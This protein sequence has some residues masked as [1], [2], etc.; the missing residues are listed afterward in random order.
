[1]FTKQHV[2][3]LVSLGL[4]AL[5]VVLLA[6]NLWAFALVPFFLMAIAILLL[7]KHDAR[8]IVLL[9]SPLIVYPL[10]YVLLGKIYHVFLPYI[11]SQGMHLFIANLPIIILGLMYAIVFRNYLTK[12]IEPRVRWWAFGIA[13]FMLVVSF[14]AS[15]VV[16]RCYGISRAEKGVTAH[17]IEWCKTWGQYIPTSSDKFGG[18]PDY[19]ERYTLWPPVII[20]AGMLIQFGVSSRKRKNA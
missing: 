3:L 6:F 12:W 18:L 11:S 13:L 8:T 20:L 9:V 19:I 16:S 2:P 15:H 10:V 5:F 7:K 17:E 14:F 1:M 4:A